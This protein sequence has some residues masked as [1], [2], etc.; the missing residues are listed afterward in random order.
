M[1]GADPQ[2]EVQLG[3]ADVLDWVVDHE[4]VERPRRQAAADAD[5]EHAAAGRQHPAAHRLLA[6]YEPESEVGD[7]R[8]AVEE[9]DVA[10][11][12]PRPRRGG[13]AVEAD[14]LI[15]SAAAW[16]W[17]H[18]VARPRLAPWAPVVE[19]ATRWHE[20]DLAGRM[21]A[22]QAE[23]E[24]AGER[25]F[26]RWRVLNIPAEADHDPAKGETDVLGRVPGEFMVSARGRTLA[27]W[28]Q[29]KGATP[30]RFWSALYQ[31]RP[32]PESGDIWLREWWR[33]YDTVL[34]TQAADG[35]YRLDGYEVTQS[36]DCAF[37][38]TK[39]RSEERRVGKE[40]RS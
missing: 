26:D 25:H 2:D 31:G 36:W 4:N 37:R 6:G 20:A 22:K 8:D 30:A 33:R 17:W 10:A 19:V 11:D 12:L 40:G 15:Q 3:G 14:S 13:I 18:S 21:I 29:T 34:W 7:V 23:D 39:S 24:A 35:S 32:T 16:D 27:Q 1:I 9:L 28:L 38:D 5:G